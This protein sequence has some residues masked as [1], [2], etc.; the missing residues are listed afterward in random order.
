VTDLAG[1]SVTFTGTPATKIACQPNG[2][3][4]SQQG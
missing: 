1:N 4:N 2:A 3:P